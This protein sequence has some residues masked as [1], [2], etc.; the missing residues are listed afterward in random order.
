MNVVGQ[1][2]EAHDDTENIG[3]QRLE[4]QAKLKIASGVLQRKLPLLKS[5]KSRV[6]Y[7]LIRNFR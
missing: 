1:S 5:M 3:I 7:D 2:I 4:R 6:F